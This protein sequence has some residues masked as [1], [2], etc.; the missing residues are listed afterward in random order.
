[1]SGSTLT[2]TISDEQLGRFAELIYRH[3]GIRISPQKRMLISNRL[4]RRLRATGIKDYEEYYRHL[5]RVGANNPEWDAFLQEIT[6]HETYLF[7]DDVQ[8]DWL[9][10]SYCRE[11]QEAASRHTRRKTLRIWSAACSTGDEVCTIACCVAGSLNRCE[12][13]SI[14]ILGTDIGID[15]LEAARRATFG[16]R[17]M[18][19]VP[20]EWRRRFFEKEAENR[21][22]AKSDITKWLSFRQHNLLQPLST[23]PFDL[24]FVKNVLIYFDRESKRRVFTHIDK[25]LLPGGLLITGPAEGALDFVR[26]YERK[27]PWLHQKPVTVNSSRAETH[28]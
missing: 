25:Q 12:E 19:N 15:A 3:T 24:I 16:Q 28:G 17:A 27:L 23:A 20:E 8:W 14:E 6:T 1:M 2:T 13:W 18:R 21:W 22:R 11:L 10:K 9:C 7:R 5:S 4:R 26:G